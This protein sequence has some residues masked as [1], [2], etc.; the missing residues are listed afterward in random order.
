MADIF[1]VA[2]IAREPQLEARWARELQACVSALRVAG[3]ASAADA[4]ILV[5]DHR[6]AD[7]SSRLE[8]LD[9]RGKA[10]FVIVDGGDGGDDEGATMPSVL[11]QGK[12]DDALVYPFR[13]LEVLSK[14]RH[15][16]QILMW[17]EVSRM[18]ASFSQLL[19]QLHE[20]LRVAERLQKGRLPARFSELKGFK[21]SSRYLAGMRP[22]GDHFDLAESADGG[23]FSIVLSDS[24]S[25]GLSSALLSIL[26]K[27]TLKLSVSSMR[28]ASEVVTGVREELLTVLGEKD[29]LSL[30]FA[31]LSRKDYRLRYVNL[32]SSRAYYAPPVSGS[33][34]FRAMDASAQSVSRASAQESLVTHE[35]AL[36]PGGRLVMLSD[37]FVEAVGEAKMP[38]FLDRYRK[39]EPVD[40]LN[41][42]AFQVKS[43]F[44]EPDDMP[45][46]DCSALILDVDSRIIRRV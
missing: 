18:N 44:V 10:V 5:L 39:Q 45:E 4:Q 24:S 20:D 30:F 7:L 14:V 1:R 36:E 22:G 34:G 43:K 31:T 11:A 38:E 23:V 42:L 12:V 29:R 15:Y 40:T 19:E 2:V 16:Q 28:S 46:Q 17:D 41:E 25:Y 32:G 27:V 3:A 13:P 26:M 33:G 35:I 9:R 8:A 6:L 21:A 37:G